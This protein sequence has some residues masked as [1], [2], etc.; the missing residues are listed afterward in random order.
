[1][2]PKII[3]FASGTKDGGGSGFENLV[4]ATQTG[5][6]DAD[7]VAVVSNHEHGGVRARAERL[8]VPFV[9][10]NG[11]F[12]AEHYR[13]IVADSGAGW[14]AFS[15]WLR[16]ARG[17]NPQK[18]INI[19]PALLSQL[20]HRFG[21]NGMYGHHIHEAVKAVLDAGEIIESGFSMHFV[22]EKMDRGPVF[23]EYRVPLKKGMSVGEIEEV[24]KEAEHEWQPKIT[25]LVVHGK[26]RWDGKNPS[27]LVVP[28]I[29]V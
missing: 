11:S 15:G 28:K 19:H 21:G 7:I 13:Q 8:H 29:S 2:R 24:V 27:S 1:M 3:V 23:F 17:L 22:T 6:L 12:D 9:Y 26:I 18:T 4:A 25:N 14:V 20:D 5:V 10:F 16:Q